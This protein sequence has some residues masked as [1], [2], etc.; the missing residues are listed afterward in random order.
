MFNKIKLVNDLLFKT[1]VRFMI[2]VLFLI[3]IL[4]IVLLL[5]DFVLV[6]LFFVFLFLSGKIFQSIQFDVDCCLCLLFGY[7]PL[8]DYFHSNFESFNKKFRIKLFFARF[9]PINSSY[10]CRSSFI[11]KWYHAKINNNPF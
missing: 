8:Q 2:P 1:Q 4:F 5:F 9:F 6:F 3:W 10:R 11:K 7:Y